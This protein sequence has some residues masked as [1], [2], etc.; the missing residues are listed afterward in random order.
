MYPPLRDNYFIS[1]LRIDFLIL[2]LLITLFSWT[3][4]EVVRAEFLR[5]RNFG[6]V[7]AAKALGV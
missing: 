5:A 6:Y 7:L 4:L 2:M 1:L 3:A